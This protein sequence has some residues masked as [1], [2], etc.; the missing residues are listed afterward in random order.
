[1]HRHQNGVSPCFTHFS[2]VHW[3][4]A[5]R[6]QPATEENRCNA[7]DCCIP[8]VNCY[9]PPLQIVE[10][11]SHSSRCK[12]VLEFVRDR[13]SRYCLLPPGGRIGKRCVA[14]AHSAWD[15]MIATTLLPFFRYFGDPDCKRSGL[16]LICLI[17]PNFGPQ[18]VES[19]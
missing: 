1:M 10:C 18:A 14:A 13:H 4:F 15:C 8:D 17:V 11:L 16:P 6:Y 5:G 2:V 9:A 12:A 19:S 7:F 3:G